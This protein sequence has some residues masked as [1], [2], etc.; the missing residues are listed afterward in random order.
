MTNATP[1]AT[2][3]PAAGTQT[4]DVLPQYTLRQILGIWAAVTIPMSVFGWIVAPWLSH[5][6]A[7]RDPFIDSLLICF[8]VAL[9]WML[10][11]VLIVVRRE[12]GSLAW[13]RVRDALWLQAPRDPKTRRKSG[14]IWWWALMF[15]ALSGVVNALP[16]DPAGPLPR[17]LPRAILTDRVEHYFSGNWVGFAL[18]VLNAF[19]APIVEELVFRG[20]LLPRMRAV[21]GRGDVIANGTLFTLY[22]LHQP[23]SMPAT[24]IDGIVNQAYPTRRFRST[25]MG[26]IT[27]TAPSFL[28]VTAIL[29]LVL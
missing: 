18:V 5:H 27:H 28:T 22:H 1:R 21:F 17:D 24:L 4:D 8:N 9:L 12:Q 2:E 3:V 26:L 20:L 16:I 11:L 14:R 13:A 15:T 25:W 6:L 7:S 10:A 19:L 29:V 23:W